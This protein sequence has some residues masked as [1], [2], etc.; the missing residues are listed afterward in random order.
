MS[1]KNQ[2]CFGDKYSLAKALKPQFI[3]AIDRVK[4]IYLMMPRLQNNRYYFK[5]DISTSTIKETGEQIVTISLVT[6]NLDK[7]S[8]Y[9]TDIMYFD[10]S[11]IIEMPT[12]NS[13]TNSITKPN[14]TLNKQ[15]WGIITS[16]KSV[17]I[18]YVNHIAIEYSIILRKTLTKIRQSLNKRK[19]D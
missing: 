11:K 15:T 19:N 2:L 10:K 8:V 5:F 13:K 16:N 6:K 9:V 3:K 18:N 4:K 7:D 14:R 12:F 17:S 1:N